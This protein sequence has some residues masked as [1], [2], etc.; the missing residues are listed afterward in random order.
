MA[1]T[2][3][4]I[5]LTEQETELCMQT[6]KMVCSEPDGA[7]RLLEANFENGEEIYS[8]IAR[9]VDE[10]YTMYQ[11]S[12]TSD[13]IRAKLT[14]SIEGLPPAKQLLY[15]TNVL[16]AVSYTGSTL[17]MNDAWND[18]IEACK[19]ILEAVEAGKIDETEIPA[20]TIPELMDHICDHVESSA[21]LFVGSPIYENLMNACDESSPE[22]MES[23][24]AN[25]REASIAMAS[26]IYTLHARGHLDSLKD[27]QYTSPYGLGV[28]TAC[29][30]EIDAA[31]KTG[32]WEKIKPVLIK[33]SKIALTLIIGLMI[34]NWVSG[35][36]SNIS[37]LVWESINPAFLSA[38]HYG[39]DPPAIVTAIRRIGKVTG[40]LLGVNFAPD[41]SNTLWNFG[42]KV[43]RTPVKLIRGAFSQFCSW[44]TNTVVPAMWQK[45]HACRDFVCTRVIAPL[46]GAKKNAVEN[47]PNHGTREVET[48]VSTSSHVHST[49]PP[50]VRTED[51]IVT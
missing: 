4:G 16:I 10:F 32:V 22:E 42:A 45:W 40:L 19:T 26:A 48:P 25:T 23:I 20:D 7:H 5:K 24:A 46:T 43:L 49:Q 37:Y 6:L 8:E 44:I 47:E 28:L 2:I 34:F 12:V 15:L 11:E 21:V 3:D 50:A 51:I 1:L 18:R 35:I 36:A 17:Y 9:G 30:L 27:Q 38:M 31:A 41:I 39:F 29:T 14:A 33:A 13:D